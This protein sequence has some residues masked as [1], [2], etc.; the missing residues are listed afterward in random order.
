MCWTV[1]REEVSDLFNRDDDRESGELRYGWQ[2][3]I[4]HTLFGQ[5]ANRGGWNR[6]KAL[7][8]VA[9]LRNNPLTL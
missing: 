7:D 3:A 6:Q 8:V 1:P 2:A 9:Y 4:V 5:N